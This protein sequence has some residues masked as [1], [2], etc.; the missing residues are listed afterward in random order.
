MMISTTNWWRCV[1]DIEGIQASMDDEVIIT[2]SRN[3]NWGL[4]V[5]VWGWRS[6]SGNNLV[7]PSVGLDIKI[8]QT[9][10]LVKGGMTPWQQETEFGNQ[11]KSFLYAGVKH[12]WSEKWGTSVGVFRGWEFFTATDEWSFKTTGIAVGVV[13]A[14]GIFEIKSGN[15][16]FGCKYVVS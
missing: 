7:V 2:D 6:G 9:A 5:G 16:L 1:P 12:F 3:F 15:Q 8:D 4:E 11:A 14:L 13:Y 10:F